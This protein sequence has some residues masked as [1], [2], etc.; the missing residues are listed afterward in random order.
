MYQQQPNQP[1]QYRQVEKRGANHALH[2]VLTIL[3]CGLWAITGWPIA[4]AMGRQTK[5]TTYA[6][7]PQMYPQQQYPVQQPPYGYPPQQQ[8]QNPYHGPQ[9]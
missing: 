9:Q 5:T 6:P 1:Q 2:V 7:P 8:Q 3:T 4:T